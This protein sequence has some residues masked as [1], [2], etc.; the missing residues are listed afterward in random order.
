MR[1]PEC[2]DSFVTLL[3]LITE[4]YRLLRSFEARSQFLQMQLQL[5]DDFRARL[6]HIS[7]TVGSPWITPFPQLMNALW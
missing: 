4:R 5:L 2:A 6:V 3:Q 7:R 1:V